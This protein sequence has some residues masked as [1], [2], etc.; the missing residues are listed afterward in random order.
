MEHYRP[1]KNPKKIIHNSRQFY[2]N[3]LP[4]AKLKEDIRDFKTNKIPNTVGKFRMKRHDS[5]RQLQELEE[6]QKKID[7]V[8]INVPHL[9][10]PT[11]KDVEHN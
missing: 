6:V 4:D 11:E 1:R 5:D 8:E 3:T 7:A 10:I 2:Q 9:N